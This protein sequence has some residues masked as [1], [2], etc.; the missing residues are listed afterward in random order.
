MVELNVQIDGVD[1][2]VARLRNLG[3][4]VFGVV[5]PALLRA[6]YRT[7]RDAK[8]YPPQRPTEYVRTM[9]LGQSWFTDPV[10]RSGDELRLMIGTKMEYAPYVRSEERQAWM[11][12]GHWRTDEEIKNEQLGPMVEEMRAAILHAAGS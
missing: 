8:E 3:T 12:R 1:A 10:V 11:H 7:E 4:D 6:G 9:K 5:E 2:A